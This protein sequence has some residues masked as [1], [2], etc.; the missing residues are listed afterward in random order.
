VDGSKE[1]Q[2]VCDEADGSRVHHG[3]SIFLSALL[4][5]WV[6]FSDGP[7]CACGPS[8]WVSQTVRPLMRTVR[9][10]LRGVPKFFA[11]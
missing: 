10:R 6:A 7:S 11:S 2:T 8:A 9:L 5:V 3:W 1:C 4:V